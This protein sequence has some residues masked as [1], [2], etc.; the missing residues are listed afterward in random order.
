MFTNRRSK[1]KILKIGLKLY[2]TIAKPSRITIIT[3]E[4]VGNSGN[5]INRDTVDLTNENQHDA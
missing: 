5:I 4:Q 1:N 2:Y 3:S